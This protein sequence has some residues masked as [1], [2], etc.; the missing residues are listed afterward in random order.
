CAVPLLR[1]APLLRETDEV[2][3]VKPG[4][5]TRALWVSLP[6]CA[7]ILLFAGTNELTQNT[8]PIPFL[9]VLPLALYLLSFII[10]FDGEQWYQRGI[11]HLL[12]AGAILTNLLIVVYVDRIAATLGRVIL[13]P[14][15][16][17]LLLEIGNV[18]LLVF[19]GCMVCHGE[20]VRLKPHRRDLTIFYLMVSAGGALGGVFSVVVAPLL[21]RAFWD[22]RFAVWIC[23]VL[24]AISLMRD[25]ASWIYRRS[26]AVGVAILSASLLFPL[27]IKA[28][29]YPKTYTGVALLVVAAVSM[30]PRWKN[31]PRWLARQGTVTQLSMVTVIAL[32]AVIYVNMI[33]LA[34]QGAVFVT[35]N[36][37]GIFRVVSTDA[38]DHSWHSYRLLNGRIT[39]GAQFTSSTFPRLRYYP[40][41]YY[42]LNSGVGLVMMN[43]P[44]RAQPNDS[45]L[46]VGVVGLGVGTVA[47]WGRPG[48]YFRFYEINPAVIGLATD[49][50]G[51]FSFIR[52]SSA[53]VDIISGDARLSMEREL[54]GG[55]SQQF[56]VLV[57]DAFTG[58]AVPTHLLTREAML[59]YLR[60]LKPDGVLAVHVS[61]LYLDLR[62]VLAEHARTLHLQYGFVHVDEKD[63]VDWASDWVLLSRDRKIFEQPE[64]SGRLRASGNIRRVRP[65]TDDYSNLFQLLN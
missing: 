23:V 35:R 18:L 7:A 15:S 22:F 2:Q 54:A 48:D 29:V 57:V 37:Y 16:M 51:Y 64:I 8:A 34:M 47:A 39:H 19:A 6:A 61:N 38:P 40:T 27:L 36:F 3:V 26:S 43:H 58:D 45:S 1:G 50:N 53:R 20:L 13:T 65:W 41:T 63:S 4:L 11:F 12:F 60:E 5:A 46:R 32:L 59:V 28:V 30:V 55:Q 25:R 44:R 17:I 10:C 62:P 14:M 33:T 56:D 31:A 49:P 42:C 21:F 52:D 9:W 24:M